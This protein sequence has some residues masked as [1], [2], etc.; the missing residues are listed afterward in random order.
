MKNKLMWLG[1]ALVAGVVVYEEFFA[2]ASVPAGYAPVN[3]QAGAGAPLS[4]AT[5]A[6]KWA[7]VLPAGAKWAAQLAPGAGWGQLSVTPGS[8]APGLFT[9]S[10][11]TAVALAWTDSTGAAQVSAYQIAA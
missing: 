1:A 8:N 6:G 2:H 11:P 4:I 9:A 10:A 7:F 3:V 5:S